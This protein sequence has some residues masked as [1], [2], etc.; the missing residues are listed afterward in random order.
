MVLDEWEELAVLG[1]PFGER[2]K[3]AFGVRRVPVV[4]DGLTICIG[5][6]GF[7]GVVGVVGVVGHVVARWIAVFRERDVRD[8]PPLPRSKP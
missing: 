3:I 4:L 2:R 5:D 8:V 6:R 1:D 7:L